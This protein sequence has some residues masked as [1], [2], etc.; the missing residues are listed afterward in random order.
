M[1]KRSFLLLLLSFL[2]L[3]L[4]LPADDLISADPHEVLDLIASTQH[5]SEHLE[6]IRAYAENLSAGETRDSIFRNTG[7]RL[8]MSG[9][10]ETAVS[11]LRKADTDSRLLAAHAALL[12]GNSNLSSSILQEIIRNVDTPAV[13]QQAITILGLSR[14]ADGNELSAVSIFE[15]YRMQP[16]QILVPELLYV[17]IRYE[18]TLDQERRKDP[19]EYYRILQSR[20]PDHPVTSLSRNFLRDGSGS[21]QR[22]VNMPS[23]EIFLFSSVPQIP[24]APSEDMVVETETA[25][26][27]DGPSGIQIGSFGLKEN[28]EHM[29]REM[30]E[31][32]FPVLID[33]QQ[34]SDRLY[35]SVIVPL[36]SG[37]H[38]ILRDSFGSTDPERIYLEIRSAGYDGFRIY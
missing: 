13:R 30:E 12:I 19:G 2:C 25:D 4:S 36:S 14:I 23:P 6:S 9:D 22:I 3:N 16:E 29:A 35:Y 21:G 24:E 17:L 37:Y 11:F 5:I 7:L 34:R 18:L 31:K 1:H 8:Y 27:A 15:P 26:I 10:L 33:E 38:Q 20:F 28:A 32:G